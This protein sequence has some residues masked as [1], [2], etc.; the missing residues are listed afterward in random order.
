MLGIAP[1]GDQP[2]SA[3]P[4]TTT[5]VV[6]KPGAWTPVPAPGFGWS[7]VPTPPAS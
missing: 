5:T 3:L 6:A 4:T 7:P 1:L 2:T